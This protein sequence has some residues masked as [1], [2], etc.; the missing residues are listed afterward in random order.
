MSDYFYDY[1]Y[2]TTYC[3]PQA[4]VLK[5]KLN[6]KDA[7]SLLE[8]E[9]SITALRILELKQ[10]FPDGKLDFS[11]FK[12]LHFYIFQDIYGWAGKTRTVNISKGSQFCLCQFIDDQAIELFQ[13]LERENYLVDAENIAER[14]SFYLSELNAIHPFREGNGRAQRMFIEILADRAGYEVDLSEVTAEE[15]I[16]AS[17]QSFNQNYDP[18]NAIMRR[19][20]IPKE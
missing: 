5:N 2:D 20:T 12:H 19:I 3:Y 4:N 1:E 9:R 13:K 14:L 16:E 8:A 7:D 11:Y 18:M 15:M 10:S 6:I 17:Y